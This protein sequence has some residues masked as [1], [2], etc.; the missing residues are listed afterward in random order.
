LH[1]TRVGRAT[2]ATT[3]D[4]DEDEAKDEDENIIEVSELWTNKLA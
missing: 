4:K 1:G 2:C 3:S